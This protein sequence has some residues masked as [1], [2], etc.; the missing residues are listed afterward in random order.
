MTQYVELDLGGQ[1]N[2]GII[3]LETLMYI[4]SGAGVEIFFEPEFPFISGSC[5]INFLSG[6]ISVDGVT[7]SYPEA[8][9]FKLNLI[10]NLYSNYWQ[11]LINDIAQ[12][13]FV[14]GVEEI[15]EITFTNGATADYYI[16]DFNFDYQNPS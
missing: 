1:H 12:F 2:T 9:W 7:G 11:L 6:I 10:G 5:V 8:T 13:Q 4:E 14:N 16:D 15:A 3:T